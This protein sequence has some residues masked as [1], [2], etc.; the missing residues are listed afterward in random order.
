VLGQTDPNR[1][2]LIAGTS[3]GMT[4]DIGTGP[5]NAIP[6]ASLGLPANGTIFNRLDAHGISWTNYCAS[7]PTG[8]TPELYPA[9]DAASESQHVKPFEQFFADAVAG[10]LPAFS[11]LDPDYS[12]QSQENPQNIVVGEALLARVV[13]AVGSAPTWPKVLLVVA[14]DEHGGYYDHVPPPPALA[15]DAIPPTVQPGE[16]SY[17]GF[18]RYGFRVPAMVVSPYANRS[19][20]T[21]VV[22]DH[23]SIPAML[24]AKWNLPAMTFRDANA[25]DL[26]DFLDLAA[27][28]RRHPVFPELPHLAAPGDTPSA[29]QC[30]STGPGTIPPPGSISPGS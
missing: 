26:T 12:N 11:L 28:R 23:T 9:N 25:N 19:L 30:S 20:V 10:G 27:L 21:S 24:E 6:D 15:P 7:Y 16:S 18:R 22:H 3:S 4:D 17:D 5:G 13:R 14:W 8:A 1:R 2:Y 29:L